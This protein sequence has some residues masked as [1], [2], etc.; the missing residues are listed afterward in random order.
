[1]ATRI[2]LQDPS[3][4]YTRSTTSLRSINLRLD[5]V[6]VVEPNLDYHSKAVSAGSRAVTAPL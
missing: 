4:A 6:P 1:M 5:K 3:D 2:S